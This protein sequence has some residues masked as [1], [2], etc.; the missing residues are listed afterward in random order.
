MI[1]LPQTLQLFLHAAC[2]VEV[3]RF[4]DFALKSLEE[5][6]ADKHTHIFEYNEGKN[7]FQ[8]GAEL[9]P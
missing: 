9:L 5:I 3:S 1:I 4:T 2:N 8:F 6:L 7:N